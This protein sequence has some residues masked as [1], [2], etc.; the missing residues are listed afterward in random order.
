MNTLLVSRIPTSCIRQWVKNEHILRGNSSNRKAKRVRE[1][2]GYFQ[3]LESHL[4]DFFKD[5]RSMKREIKYVD[6]REEGTNYI[7]NCPD[8]EFY[9]DFKFSNN[10]IYKF[11]SRN[12]LVNRAVTHQ[13]HQPDIATF[14]RALNQY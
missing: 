12:D 4:Y 9:E 14:Q 2:K 5:R 3:E 8:K 11:L 6:V 13:A 10:W 1:P 7:N